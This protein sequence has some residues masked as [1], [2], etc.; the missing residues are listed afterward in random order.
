MAAM[1]M[2]LTVTDYPTSTTSTGYMHGSAAVI[3]LQVLP[4]LGHGRARGRRRSR[5]PP[6]SASRSS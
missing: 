2:D 5:T 1:A 6:T 3:G 4:V